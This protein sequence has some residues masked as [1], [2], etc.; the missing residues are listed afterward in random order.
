MAGMIR[1]VLLDAVGTLM[2]PYPT[3]GGVYSRAAASCG[4]DCRPGVLQREF[5]Q[6]Y[7]DLLPR[8]FH[9]DTFGTSETRERNWWRAAV[10]RAFERAGCTPVPAAVVEACFEAF[11]S[12]RTWR[13]YADVPPLLD[14]LKRR[15]VKLGIVSNFDSR[16]RGVVGDLGLDR[17]GFSLTISSET[18]FAKPSPRIYRAALESLGAAPGE[19]L[20]VGDRREQDYDGPRRAGLHALWLVRDGSRR[21]RG[22]VRSLRGLAGRIGTPLF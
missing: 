14:E 18:R 15:G 10:K 5:R 6:A 11:A 8:R 7:R 4:V 9:G 13:L 17:Y 16:L 1:A 22:V 3:V 21:G 12:G 2:R 20:F 19:T